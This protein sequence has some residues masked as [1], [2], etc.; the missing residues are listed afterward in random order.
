MPGCVLRVAGS[1][2]KVK[3]FLASSSL[4]PAKV[5]YKGDLGFIKS[6]GPTR[7]SGFNVT[8]SCSDG[9]SISKQAKE[10]ARFIN[11][12]RKE[13]DMIKAL[14]FKEATLDFGLWDLATEDRPWPIYRLPRSIID[15]ASE[16]GFDIELSF[17]GKS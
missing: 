17:Y 2:R 1:T 13:F 5:Y 4:K 14:K 8:L 11:A 3:Q 12:Y 16:Y 9:S 6:R 7:I 15:L 10:A